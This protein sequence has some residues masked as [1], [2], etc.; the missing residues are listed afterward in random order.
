[1]FPKHITHQEKIM[2]IFQVIVLTAT[3]ALGLLAPPA[4]MA[5]TPQPG[6]RAKPCCSVTAV[7][8]QKGVVTVLDAK[9][10]NSVE[11]KVKPRMLNKIKVGQMTNMRM[12]SGRPLGSLSWAC[13][14][15]MK[16]C[17]CEKGADCDLV[18]VDEPTGCNDGVCMCTGSG[19][20]PPENL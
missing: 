6:A 11:V 2:K 9:S 20:V 8:K 19:T 4:A 10:G 3:F 17:S 7:D 12:T 5:Q 18:C 1:M 14:E 16:T 13:T 15:D